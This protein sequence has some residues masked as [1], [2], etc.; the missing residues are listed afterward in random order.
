MGI[1]VIV[2]TD[3]ERRAFF[4]VFGDHTSMKLSVNYEVITWE[5]KEGSIGS[6]ICTDAIH[7]IKSGIGEIAAAATTQYLID[8]YGVSRIVNYG[9]V[10]SLEDGCPTQKVGF[11]RKVVHYGMRNVQSPTMRRLYDEIFIT[12]KKD[13]LN[14]NALGL[15]EFICVSADEAIIGS[16]PKD[17]FR[18][19][20]RA[21]VYDMEAAGI[22]C[23]SNRNKIPVSFIK[24]IASGVSSGDDERYKESIYDAACACAQ[25]LAKGIEQGR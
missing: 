17:I 23:V 6:I 20:F 11:V 2:A 7:L 15:E 14:V 4:N 5:P 10:G 13:A 9:T 8:Q 3:L 16:K 22:L 24:A 12:P 18:Q 1:G 19:E 25:A 21:N